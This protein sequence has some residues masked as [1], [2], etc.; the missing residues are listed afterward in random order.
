[1][2]EQLNQQFNSGDEARA[3]NA[4]LQKRMREIDPYISENGALFSKLQEFEK[5]WRDNPPQTDAGVVELLASSVVNPEGKSRIGVSD[6][7]LGVISRSVV[8]VFLTECLGNIDPK[9]TD[10][11]FGHLIDE[12]IQTLCSSVEEHLHVSFDKDGV[13][14]IL[15]AIKKLVQTIQTYRLLLLSLCR[16]QMKIGP[17]LYW[18]KRAVLQNCLVHNAFRT[19]ISAFKDAGYPL[20]RGLFA[21]CIKRQK[22]WNKTFPLTLLLN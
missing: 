10:E 8:D 20:D 15:N 13:Q 4:A 5:E 14:V 19:T 17:R 21:P 6:D 3:F 16:K 9:I 1:M 12:N 11:E 18:R 22:N 2:T 7:D